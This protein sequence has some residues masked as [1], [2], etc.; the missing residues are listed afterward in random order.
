MKKIWL[1]LLLL[2]AAAL[3]AGCAGNADTAPSSPTPG[4]TG[5]IESILPGATDSMGNS[6]MPGAQATDDPTQPGAGIESVQDAR[7]RSQA[8]E[9]AVEKLSEVED[10][11]VVA[12]GHT[13]AVGVK[14]AQQYQGKVDDRLKK[15]VL[16]RAQTVE[17]GVTAV[18]VTA[19]DKLVRRIQELSETLENAASMSAVSS[20]VDELAREITVYTE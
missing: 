5:I 10:A 4:A 1:L 7:A 15:M 13:A 19:D 17:K 16:A 9:E 18:A 6:P 3:L 14:F 11:W 20:Q 8:M 2:T 12:A